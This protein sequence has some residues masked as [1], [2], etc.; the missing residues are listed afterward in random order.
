MGYNLVS[1]WECE[2]PEVSNRH[3]QKKFVPCPHYIVFDF[4]AVLRRLNIGLTLDLKIDCSHIPTS[5]AI[6]DSLTNEPIFIENRD[7]ERLIEEFV[8]ELTRRQEI[9]SREVWNRYPLL[10]ESSEARPRKM[11]EL[12]KPS[13]CI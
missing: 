4:E 12:G 10:D 1:V 11:D 5:I 9:I 7:P 8:A 13:S 6:N 2:N 3:L